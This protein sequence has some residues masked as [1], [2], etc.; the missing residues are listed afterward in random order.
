M[1]LTHEPL[2]SII[3]PTLNS[4]ATLQ[5]CLQAITDQ[6]MPRSEYEIVIADAGSQDETV[7]IA[8]RCGVDKV[9]TNELKTGEAGKAAGITASNGAL[10]ALIDSDNILPDRNWLERMTAPFKNAGIV[11]SEPLHYTVR[12]AD[13]PLTRYFAM[14]GMN[15]PLCLFIG[16]Y[17]RYCAVT[18]KWTGV[19]LEQTDCGDYLEVSLTPQAL[20]TIGANGFIFHRLLLE[21][22]Q[23]HPYFFDIDVVHQA[24]CAGHTQIAKVKTG[25]IHLYCT[26]L[27]DFARKQRRRI[28]DY[29]YFSQTR[30]RTYP[31]DQQKRSGVVLFC[32]A[33][34][35]VWPLLYQMVRGYMRRPDRAWLYHIPACWI[36]LWLYGTATLAK[37]TGHRQAPVSR[38]TWQSTPPAVK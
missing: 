36:T 2:L 24:V 22:V 18:G 4:A 15:D 29:L 11:A 13:H 37:I 35:L 25:I 3:I 9:V 31:W 23:W 30:E 6:T 38:D 8:Q 33:T 21:E 14:L 17:D 26:R 20:P 1:K 5:Q 16:N 34:V 12:P 7:E 19:K 10:I 27:G 28:R 32:I